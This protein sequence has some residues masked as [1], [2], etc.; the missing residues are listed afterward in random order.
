M[1]DIFGI[2][3]NLVI[4]DGGAGGEQGTGA[5]E[6]Q[7][8]RGNASLVR[9]FPEIR[10]LTSGCC[11]ERCL[12]RWVG[13]MLLRG[14]RGEGDSSG[15]EGARGGHVAAVNPTPWKFGLV[16]VWVE[17]SHSR[18]QWRARKLHVAMGVSSKVACRSR[19][20]G[21]NHHI[22]CFSRVMFT[23]RNRSRARLCF[24]ESC[25]M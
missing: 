1:V 23:T 9:D 25:D 20:G 6:A 7:Q 13:P 17:R 14:C 12:P 4:P 18:T 24:H 8:V 22:S 19:V 16:R 11:V 3:F 2:P 5:R 15:Y 10:S 21:D